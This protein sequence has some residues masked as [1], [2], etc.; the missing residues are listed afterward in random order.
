M[1]VQGSAVRDEVLRL[2]FWEDNAKLG[3]YVSI[4]T[5]EAYEDQPRTSVEL[6]RPKFSEQQDLIE[7]VRQKKKNDMT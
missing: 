7:A 5:P 6:K 4:Q 3:G 2:L 1:P